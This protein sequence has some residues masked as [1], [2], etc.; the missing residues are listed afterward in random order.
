[1][2][3][4]EISSLHPTFLLPLKD[5]YALCAKLTTAVATVE[6]VT[7]AKSTNSE[8]DVGIFGISGIVICS[9]RLSPG[10]T[11][12]IYNKPST[13]VISLITVSSIF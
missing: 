7:I 6:P 8:K 11:E 12:I 4:R 10:L 5:V 13:Y 3:D 2:Q 1:M 9:C